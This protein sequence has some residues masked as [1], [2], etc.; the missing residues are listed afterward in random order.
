M[1]YSLVDVLVFAPL[2]PLLG[3]ILFWFIQLLMIE[4]L[5]YNMSKIWENHRAFCRFSN[6]IGILF[7]AI[8]HATGY[9]ITG[10]GV[11][12][13]S[14]SVSE[15]KVS[16]KKEKKGFPEWIA[17]AF[18]ALGPFFIPPFII[19]CILFLIPGVL[20][21]SPVPGYTFSQ[22]LISFGSLLFQFGTGF[23][24]LLTNLDLL[25]PFHLSFALLILLVGLGIR[26]SYIGEEKK[27]IGMLYDLHLIKKLIVEHPL[28]VL[29]TL[30]VLYLIS[31]I[32]FFLKIP[33]YALLFA[34]F[35][36][37]ALIAI[38]AILL[39]HFVV[40][41]LIISD[42]LPSFKRFLPF[43]IPVV[44]YIALRILFLAFPSDFVY[45]ISLLLSILITIASCFVLIKLETNKLKKLSEIKQEEEEDGKGRG[46]T[47]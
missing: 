46:D 44:S 42:R 36:W 9:T 24:I 21:V 15:S 39:A 32:M 47:S 31:V 5:K 30:A 18:L 14:L 41:L 28:Y 34:F 19:F 22:M 2:A 16:P 27:K 8:A 6:F 38:V 1:D 12:E 17:N 29:I 40:F 37:L 45:S 25:N 26:P 13:F 4:S 23:L 33:F 20:N 7:Q 43:L 35:G 3:L 10:I 11:S